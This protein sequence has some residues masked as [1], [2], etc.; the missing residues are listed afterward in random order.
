MEYDCL[1]KQTETRLWQTN[2][3]VNVILLVS[4]FEQV[5]K[6]LLNINKPSSIYFSL[7][8]S[9]SEYP[10]TFTMGVGRKSDF[11]SS[12]RR[13]LC[14]GMSRLGRGFQTCTSKECPR[15]CLWLTSWPPT[16]HEGHGNCPGCSESCSQPASA[17]A[18]TL[19]H[20][21]QNHHVSHPSLLAKGLSEI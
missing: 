16:A 15:R 2:K 8:N 14:D 3:N 13:W 4:W 7:R 11:S 12:V 9:V 18:R 6:T 10:F 17:G 20:K 19:S 21:G 1:N 5:R